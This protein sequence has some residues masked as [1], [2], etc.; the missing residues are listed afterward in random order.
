MENYEII[1][2]E[3][4]L[5]VI[6]TER[7]TL[8]D[9]EV[10]DISDE[11][12]G[13]LNNSEVNKYLEVRFEEQTKEMVLKYVCNALTNIKD[14]MHFGI[15]DN[16]GTRLIG[17]VTLRSIN[18]KHLYSD[19]SFVVGHPEAP[20]GKG[21]ATEAV[22]AVVNY[23]FSHM[24]L[25]KLWAGYYDGH[26][27]SE[28][29]LKN[30]GFTEEGRQ[31]E[32]HV[33]FSGNRVDKAIV[34]LLA[35]EYLAFMKVIYKIT[36]PNGKIYIGEDLTGSINYFGSASSLLIEKDFTKEQ[37]S[38]FTIRK[39]ILWESKIASDKEVNIKEVEFIK[40]F[41]SNDPDIGYNKWPKFDGSNESV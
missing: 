19:I 8:R 12:I 7:L 2:R 5:P 27:A 16:G 31:K 37:S 1:E 4:K 15:Y 35:N 14:I 3:G 41:S 40:S 36:Y 26:I 23:V 22:R 38:D 25:Q 6:R 20:R 34:G 17:S 10:Q 11:Y 18:R 30:V 39:E 21:Y 32:H 33:E 9:I 28:K 24:D 29:V 13:W